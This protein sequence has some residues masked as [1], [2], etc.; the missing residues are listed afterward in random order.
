MSRLEQYG[1]LKR[2]TRTTRMKTTTSF[3]RDAEFW[4]SATAVDVQAELVK[5]DLHAQD[6]DGWTPLHLAAWYATN[7][8]VVRVL[9]EAGADLHAQDEDGWTPLHLAAYAGTPAV[10]TALLE[11]GANLEAR[12]EDGRTLCMWRR[13][14]MRTRR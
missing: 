10:V 9:L 3:P 13:R 2:A 4:K 12:D 6:E 7:P 5:S 8:A 14:S 11:A 1:A